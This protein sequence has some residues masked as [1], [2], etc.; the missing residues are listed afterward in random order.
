VYRFL[1]LWFN[2]GYPEAYGRSPSQTDYAIMVLQ[3]VL[4]ILALLGLRG[5]LWRTWPLW[6]SILA[7][8]FIYMAVD[9]RLLY[10][11][12]VMP[13]VISLSAGGAVFLLRKL[14]PQ[15]FRE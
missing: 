4:L 13:L 1:P 10:L 12:P 14:F 7:I 5:V 9:A 3:G 2:W 15:A 11:T 8:C 6:G